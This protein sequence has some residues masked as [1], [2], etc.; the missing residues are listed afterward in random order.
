MEIQKFP[1]AIYSM[2]LHFF[3]RRNSP[4]FGWRLAYQKQNYN[5]ENCE[6]LSNVAGIVTRVT[7]SRVARLKIV[8]SQAFVQPNVTKQFVRDYRTQRYASP[9]CYRLTT[10][11]YRTQRNASPK[12]YHL[13]TFDYRTFFQSGNLGRGFHWSRNGGRGT[14]LT[15]FQ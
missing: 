7:L 14:C 11:V 5:N 12:C 1:I 10:F 8:C 9:K 3:A 15:T 13:N 4:C 6:T 2:V